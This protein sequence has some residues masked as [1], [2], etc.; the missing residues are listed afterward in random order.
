MAE[1]IAPCFDPCSAGSPSSAAS[2]LHIPAAMSGF[3][4]LFCWITLIGSYTPIFP[5]TCP[6][7]SILVLLDH[8][9][10]HLPTHAGGMRHARGFDPCSAGSPS[11]ARADWP[12]TCGSS[13]VSILVLL[14]HPHRPR[15]AGARPAAPGVSILVLL[16]HPHRLVRRG[17]LKKYR[18]RVSILVLL[19]H[20]HRLPDSCLPPQ[21]VVEVSI[22]VL[23]DHPHRLESPDSCDLLMQGFD[24]CSAGSPSSAPTAAPA[25]VRRK[26][27]DPCSAGSRLIG[28]DE[29]VSRAE[30]ELVSILV[31]LDHPHRH[32][33]RSG[34]T[35]KQL[36]GF[37]PCSA[38][39]RLIGSGG[40]TT[41][42][43]MPAGFRSLFC[44][45]TLIGPS[46]ARGARLHAGG[47]RRVSI[48]VLLDHPHRQPAARMRLR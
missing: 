26:C 15:A 31:L 45:I 39:S 11:S 42:A 5:A 46:S 7:V 37:D 9:H 6:R 10:R 20:P 22:L 14:D 13:R 30:V 8:P 4:S 24:P 44:W 16:D 12:C 28:V 25:R 17:D 48:L 2:R 38:G 18:G 43:S 34:T 35:P 27:F 19:D 36:R 29:D 41:S 3:R 23:L 33:V 32:G 21:H 47:V 40:S 1:V